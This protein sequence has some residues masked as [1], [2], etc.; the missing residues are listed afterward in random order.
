MASEDY[1]ATFP[2]WW[3]YAPAERTG[4]RAMPINIDFD[5]NNVTYT[6]DLF[7]ENTDGAMP[8]VQS[9][10]VDNADNPDPLFILTRGINQRIIVPAFSQACR[11]VFAQDQVKLVLTTGPNLIGVLTS[12]R[13]Q[14]ILLNVPVPIF[15]TPIV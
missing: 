5:A 3:G 13:V 10:W 11:P 12:K 15:T 8:F 1:K 7:K 14:I 6:A 4:A 2:H 9:V